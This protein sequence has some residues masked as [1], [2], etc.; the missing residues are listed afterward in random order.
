MERSKY[1]TNLTNR[2]WEIIAPLTG[3]TFLK[4]R[5]ASKVCFTRDCKCHFLPG[6]Y[7][8][9]VERTAELFIIHIYL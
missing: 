7:R 4:C 8:V 9:S 6:A 2:Q 5:E 3:N 1:T